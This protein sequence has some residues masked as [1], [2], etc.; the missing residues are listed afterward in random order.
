MLHA[1]DSIA[2][3]A[4]RTMLAKI[5]KGSR[6]LVLEGAPVDAGGNA[7]PIIRERKSE[8]LKCRKERRSLKT[9]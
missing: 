3:R 9:L 5:L 7:W 6:A 8:R 2:G 1:A 4:G